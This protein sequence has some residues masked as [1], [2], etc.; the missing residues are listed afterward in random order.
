[1]IHDSVHFHS[2]AIKDVVKGVEVAVYEFVYGAYNEALQLLY[3]LT[4]ASN[5]NDAVEVAD[6]RKVR[7]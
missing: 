3:L 1:M 2:D 4:V 7:L 6:V 5:L